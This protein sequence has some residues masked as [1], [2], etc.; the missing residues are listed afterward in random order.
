MA[1][2]EGIGCPA[3]SYPGGAIYDG[4][5][6]GRD[7]A[8]G[9][10]LCKMHTNARK[11]REEASAKYDAE[12]SARRAREQRVKDEAA[13]LVALRLRV[14]ELMEKTMTLAAEIV[15]LRNAVETRDDII[16]RHAGEAW[17]PVSA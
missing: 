4:H 15:D 2:D 1:T 12:Q 10:D 6:C 16:R 14:T 3:T 11:K 8:D 13:E 9:S 17:L 7:L 5:R